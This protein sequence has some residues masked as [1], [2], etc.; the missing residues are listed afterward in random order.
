MNFTIEISS[1]NGRGPLLARAEWCEGL[2]TVVGTSARVAKL[3]E[4]LLGQDL[5]EFVGFPPQRIEAR[6][7]S[8]EYPKAIETYLLSVGYRPKVISEERAPAR[9]GV[10]VVSTTVAVSQRPEVR[11]STEAIPWRVDLRPRLSAASVVLT[12]ALSATNSSPA[13]P[14]GHASVEASPVRTS[15]SV[16]SPS[17]AEN[18]AEEITT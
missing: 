11:T 7:G 10:S 13:N 16:S 6:R 14:T 3:L 17:T 4:G 12:I 1:G 18:W 8:A 5:A 2:V 15:A 9:L